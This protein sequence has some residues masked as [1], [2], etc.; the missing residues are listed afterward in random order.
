[1]ATFDPVILDA[2]NKQI[3]NERYNAACYLAL[4]NRLDYLN[5]SGFAA[6]MRRAADEEMTHAARITEYVIDRNG[7]PIIAP[8]QGFTAPEADMTTGGAVTFAAALQR[9]QVTTEDIKTLYDLSEQAD[10]SQT[11]QFLLWFLKEQTKSVRET[12]EL[13]ARAQFAQGC[14]AAI[15]AMDREL[16]EG[17]K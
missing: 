7:F 13:Q 15:L 3:T 10:D 9:E 14:P 11:C 1:M 6:W 2:L 16:G 4:A 8:L 5:L 12:T 17:E